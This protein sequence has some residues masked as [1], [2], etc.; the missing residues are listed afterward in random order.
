[1]GNIQEG[2]LLSA[3]RELL[4]VQTQSTSFE[5]KKLWD[6]FSARKMYI[7]T[8]TISYIRGIELNLRRLKVIAQFL[9]RQRPWNRVVHVHTGCGRN[10][11][12]F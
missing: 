10:I 9:W 12:A 11:E 2:K 6:G 1:M 3:S 8:A 4:K 5:T 7:S